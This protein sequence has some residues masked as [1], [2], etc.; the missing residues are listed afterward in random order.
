MFYLLY[1]IRIT[2]KSHFWRQIVIIASL[3]T[4]RCFGRYNVSHKSINH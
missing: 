3:C 4:Q 1:D 2:L